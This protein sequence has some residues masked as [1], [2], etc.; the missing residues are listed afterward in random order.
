MIIERSDVLKISLMPETLYTLISV[1]QFMDSFGILA[2]RV[3]QSELRN[4][5][6]HLGYKW[7]KKKTKQGFYRAQSAHR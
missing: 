6:M 5:V 3:P 7:R 2:Q 1:K 4:R